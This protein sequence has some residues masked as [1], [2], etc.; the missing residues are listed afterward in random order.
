MPRQY[1]PPLDGAGLEQL[2]L[3]DRVPPLQVALHELHRDQFVHCPLTKRAKQMHK[4]TK[5]RMK[6]LITL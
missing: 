1:V 5:K 2:R 3:R 6:S 4:R